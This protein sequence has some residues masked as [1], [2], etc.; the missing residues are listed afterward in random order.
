MTQALSLYLDVLRFGAAF[1][2]FASHWAGARYSGGLFWR[3]MDY[4]RTSVIVFFVLSGFI[5]AWVTEARERT[6]EDYAFSRIARLYSV[7]VPA[8]LLSAALDRLGIAIDPQLYGPVLRLSPAEQSLGY[9]LSLVFLGESWGLAM[10]P[11][12]NVPFWTLNYEAWY[13][14][15]F[16]AAFF[17]R[18]RHRTMVVVAAAL[19]SGPKILLL[20]PI[21]LMGLL[22]WRWRAAL[23][24]L[25]GAPLA[26]A[27]VA[28]F[29][30]LEVLG[31]RQ[32]FDEAATPWLPFSYSAYDYVVGALVAVFIT[33]LANTPLRLPG[34]RERRLIRWLAG[35]SFGLY[36]YHYP[37]LNLFATVVPGSA[38][39]TMH[40]M[41]VFGLTLG[42]ALP[43]AYLTEQWKKPMK[44]ML[45]SGFDAARRKYRDLATNRRGLC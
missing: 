45:H 34:D 1:T 39:G 14:V 13:Y 20:L 5:I 25:Q 27:A 36:L 19:L 6:F 29:V 30:A 26:F 11:G 37:L 23:P 15:L 22:A 44:R 32:L 12:C 40:S 28:A 10:L 24:A 38:A 9:A 35:T 43:L 4:G 41:L 2:V 33:A 31:G 17:L 7:I 8:F 3:V 21:W 16:G 18:G 42:V